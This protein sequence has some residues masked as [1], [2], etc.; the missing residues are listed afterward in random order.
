MKPSKK[1]LRSYKKKSV[2]N[3]PTQ[4]SQGWLPL[5]IKALEKDP[6]NLVRIKGLYAIS[7][8][9]RE[10]AVNRKEFLEKHDG[11]SVLL[12][13]SQSDVEKLQVCGVVRE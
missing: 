6:V 13:A 11:F 12:R 7:C 9:V 10:H 5:F 3:P 2:F 1:R 4:I 8:A